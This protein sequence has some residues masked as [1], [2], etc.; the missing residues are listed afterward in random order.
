M[1]PPPCELKPGAS[2]RSSAVR[3]EIAAFQGKVDA[4]LA[5]TL[6]AEEFKKCRLQLGIYGIRGLTDKQMIRVKVPAG[7]LSAEQMEC[8]AKLVEEFATG[9]GHLTT[10]QDVQMY[11]VPIARTP[12]LMIRLAEAGL[13]TREA[14]GNSVRNV[15]ACPF[16]GLCAD[17]RFD[18]APYALAV[19]QHFL[20]NPMSQALPRKFK[21][22]FSGCRHDCAMA[23]IHDIGAIA[24]ESNGRLGF[25]LYVGGGLG[26]FPRAA[27]LLEPF[28]SVE[29]LLP[30]CEAILHVFDQHGER[31][32]KARARLKFLIERL[33]FEAFEALVV[34]ERDRLLN[35]TGRFATL[36]VPQPLPATETNHVSLPTKGSAA[37][38]CWVKTNVAPQ[39]QAGF[40]IVTVRLPLGDLAASQMRQLASLAHRVSQG[41]LLVTQ[42]Q[43]LCLPWVPH[44][45]LAGVFEEVSR[46]GLALA[47]ANRIQDITACPGADTCQIGITSSRGLATVLTQLLD[48]PVY[49]SDDLKG[50]RIKISGCPNSCGQHHIADVGFFGLARSI[51]G[52]LAPHYQLLVGGGCANGEVRFG[53]PVEKIPA[54]YVPHVVERLLQ[55]YRRQRL[56]H[57]PFSAFVD[58]V[59]IPALQQRLREF[60]AVKSYAEDPELFRDWGRT[61]EFTLAGAGQGECAS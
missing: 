36:A 22:S 3:E 45:D 56:D 25:R 21:I 27:H 42:W 18:V 34:V 39:R 8:L 38:L 12:E 9:R 48:R 5:K 29:R 58:R 55:C 30:T 20:R 43:D 41:Q 50:L 51:E 54:K 37:F 31:K 10:R 32:N 19:T 61:T 52:K 40:M 7:R 11:D 13:T 2:A 49:K 28:T 6:S 24:A 16:A 23:P 57:E 44:A 15:T 26:A 60:A 33:G 1:S 53:R 17:E 59:G 46:L 14:C 47:D 4:Y 35:E